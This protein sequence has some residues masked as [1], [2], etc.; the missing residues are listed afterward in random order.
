MAESDVIFD[1]FKEHSISEFFRKNRHMLGYSGKLRS[2][3][4]IIHEL[5]TNSLDACEEAEILPDINIEIKKD[6]QIRD[7]SSNTYIKGIE[8]DIGV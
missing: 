4:T 6:L 3:T 5:V 7:V 1:E 8:Y 2:M